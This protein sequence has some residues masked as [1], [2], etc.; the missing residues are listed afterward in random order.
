[1]RGRLRAA[2]AARPGPALDHKAVVAWNGM[3]LS[4]LAR[5]AGRLG[6]ARYLG[7]AARLAERLTREPLRRT[8]AAD[9]PPAVLADRAWLATGLLDLHGVSGEQRWLAAGADL[10][11]EILTLHQEPD[12]GALVSAPGG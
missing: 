1:M 12:T 4:A 3:A 2:R 10:A 7:A 11:V 9:A 6:E 5:A 8:L